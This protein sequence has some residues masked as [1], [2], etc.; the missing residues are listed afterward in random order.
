MIN[1][2]SP[3]KFLTV[4]VV[5]NVILRVC[6]LNVGSAN[7]CDF[8]LF[9]LGSLGVPPGHLKIRGSKWFWSTFGELTEFGQKMQLVAECPSKELKLPFPVL[10]HVGYTYALDAQ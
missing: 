2:F 3:E 4:L 5:Q 6:S 8:Q 9:P 10:M 7:N 1:I